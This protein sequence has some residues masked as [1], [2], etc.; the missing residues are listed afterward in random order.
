ME[1]ALAPGGLL[2][3]PTEG[4]D[5]DLET[6]WGICR[7]TISA[8]HLHTNSDL[9]PDP[10]ESLRGAGGGRGSQHRGEESP[11]LSEGEMDHGGLPS[12]G[13]ALSGLPFRQGEALEGARH[14]QLMSCELMLTFVVA[15]VMM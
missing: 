3:G 15:A 14:L 7:T 1:V 13:L 8:T 6:R 4:A 12:A 11:S 9:Q 10:T 5:F 2:L